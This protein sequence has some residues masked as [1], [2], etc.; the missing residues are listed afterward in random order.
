MIILSGFLFTADS[1]FLIDLELRRNLTNG[2][3]FPVISVNMGKY[4]SFRNDMRNEY[5][6]NG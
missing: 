2:F 1:F 4:K 6:P 5:M 3:Y